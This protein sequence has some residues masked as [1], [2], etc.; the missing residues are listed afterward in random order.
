MVGVCMAI[1]LPLKKWSII[2]SS[3]LLLSNAVCVIS[4]CCLSFCSVFKTAFSSGA[5]VPSVAAVATRSA[6][7]KPSMR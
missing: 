4:M 5:S 6:L 7:V 3:R 2:G 1:T